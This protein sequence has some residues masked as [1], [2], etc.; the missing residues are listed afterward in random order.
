MA[1]A[2]T[3]VDRSASL[4][5]KE[6]FG[7]GCLSLLVADARPWFTYCKVVHFYH[8]II[9]D[10]HAQCLIVHS[11]VLQ[12]PPSANSLTLSVA[13]RA[14]WPLAATWLG[15]MEYDAGTSITGLQ[16]KK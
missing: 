10:I 3:T 14:P 11:L 9:M 1:D 8:S 16:V 15:V 13:S 4:V 7:T 12:H 2:A 5:D 6:S